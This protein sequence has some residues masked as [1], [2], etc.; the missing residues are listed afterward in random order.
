MSGFDSPLGDHV[1]HKEEIEFAINDLLLFHKVLIYVSSL[2]WVSD[3][4]APQ[5]EES[6]PYSLVDDDKGNVWLG[7]DG[8]LCLVDGINSSLELDEFLFNDHL[9]HCIANTI[10][11]NEDLLRQLTV[12]VVLVGFEGIEEV[13]GQN[14]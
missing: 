11:V 10:S 1:R 7:N 12:V 4:F 9:P 2:R 14:A 8:L 13:V 5:F 3:L 6:F